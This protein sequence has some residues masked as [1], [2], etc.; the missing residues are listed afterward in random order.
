GRGSGPAAAPRPGTRR[1]PPPDPPDGG[2]ACTP[3]QAATRRRAA[4]SSSSAR[5]HSN[6]SPAP[7]GVRLAK[8]STAGSGWL[9]ARGI[10]RRWRRGVSPRAAP[11]AR[12]RGTASLGRSRS[13][14]APLG[15]GPPAAPATAAATAAALPALP[16]R[17]RGRGRRPLLRTGGL[18][19]LPGVL[20]TL[21]LRLLPGLLLGGRRRCPAL[22][23][24]VLPTVT[25]LLPVPR[26]ALGDGPVELEELEGGDPHTGA[27]LE[28]LLRQPVAAPHQHQ[29]SCGEGLG[30]SIAAEI[31][32]GEEHS[33]LRRLLADV[34]PALLDHAPVDRPVAAE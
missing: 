18:L 30:A 1:P 3:P 23:P 13:R 20:G 5:H 26:H 24:A 12:G 16:G 21:G 17:L 22:P 14:C 7:E 2:R 15:P 6:R 25:G 10:L 33:H 34:P 11:G 9:G 32:G 31:S 29:R 19:C 28:E 27:R 4:G 8:G